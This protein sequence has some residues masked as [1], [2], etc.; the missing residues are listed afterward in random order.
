M[1]VNIC[2]KSVGIIE[3]R[4]GNAGRSILTGDAPATEEGEDARGGIPE[5][6]NRET[7]S[8]LPN[9]KE[10]SRRGDGL[11]DEVRRFGSW[12]CT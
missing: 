6:P 8:R 10:F 3:K 11:C 9:N 2:V 5:D 4:E 12:L 1:C 7:Q